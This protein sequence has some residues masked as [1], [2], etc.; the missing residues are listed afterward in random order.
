MPRLSP[1]EIAERTPP[2]RYRFADF[3]RVAAILVVV[4]GHWLL[5]IVRV[6]DGRLAYDVMLDE[7]DWA[8][9]TTWVFQVMPVFF[10]VGGY[11]NAKSLQGAR[12]NGTRGTDWLRA[13]AMR[14]YWPVLPLLVVWT[15]IAA[16]LAAAG[17]SEEAISLSSQVVLVPAAKAQDEVDKT[18]VTI[19]ECYSHTGVVLAALRE[20]ESLAPSTVANQPA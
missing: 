7:L 16:A 12:Q 1:S 10:I 8:P 14:L 4:F 20:A 5:L 6:D 9:W 11:A 18:A 19:T 2:D 15:G 3:L 13:R 17:A